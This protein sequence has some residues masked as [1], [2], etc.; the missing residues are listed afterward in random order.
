M[1]VLVLTNEEGFMMMETQFGR[2]REGDLI[3]LCHDDE[4]YAAIVRSVSPPERSFR[5]VPIRKDDVFRILEGNWSP[6]G[7]VVVRL[8]DDPASTRPMWNKIAS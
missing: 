8:P 1:S 3:D 4:R 6:G 5:V 7:D 2:L